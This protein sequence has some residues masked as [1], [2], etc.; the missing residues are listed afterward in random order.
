M[1]PIEPPDSFHLLAAHGWME[2]GSPLEAKQEL[3]KLSP[4]SRRHPD[5][6]KVR[7]EIHAKEGAWDLCA[8]I[9]QALVELEPGESFGWVNR[10]YALRRTPRGGLQAAYDALQPAADHLEDLEQIHF[11]LACYACQLG[12]LDDGRLWL[13]KSF[14]TARRR[15][16]LDQIKLLARRAR[17]PAAVDRA[18]ESVSGRPALGRIV[19]T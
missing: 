3:Q 9:G 2:L 18:R 8:E 7:W 19:L 16:A 10:S 1:K 6:L 13:S 5:V 11:N 4:E 15:G 12:R 17:P 14:A